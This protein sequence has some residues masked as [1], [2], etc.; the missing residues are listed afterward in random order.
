MRYT[1]L[2]QTKIITGNT[3]MD[4][5]EKLNAALEEVARQSARYELTFNTSMGFCAYVVYEVS[6]EYA[7]T[8]AD[9]YELRGVKYCCNDCPM[10]RPSEDKRVKYTTCSHGFPR[11]G[12]NDDA[13]DWFYEELEKG[14]I[15]L[16]CGEAS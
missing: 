10:F 9:E 13:C 12:A 4:F 8:V 7:E 5:Q 2:K 11:R 3:A 14:G 15:K 6:R 1:N 16:L